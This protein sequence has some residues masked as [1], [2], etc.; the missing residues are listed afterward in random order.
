MLIL[1]P[2][3]VMKQFDKFV[4]LDTHKDTFAVAMSGVNGG[5]TRYYGEIP[6]TAKGIGVLSPLIAIAQAIIHG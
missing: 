5:P 2:G 4:G 6:N 3:A 1:Q